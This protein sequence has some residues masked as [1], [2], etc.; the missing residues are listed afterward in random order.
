MMEDGSL[1]EVDFLQN[2]TFIRQSFSITLIGRHFY[3][4]V[5]R[6]NK[7]DLKDYWDLFGYP[8]ELT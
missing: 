2:P 7:A 3:L 8:Y 4:H 5:T 1:Y 6:P